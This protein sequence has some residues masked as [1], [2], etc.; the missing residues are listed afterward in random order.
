[1]PSSQ[2]VR[3]Y[4]YMNNA[5]TLAEQIALKILINDPSEKEIQALVADEAQKAGIN[6]NILRHEAYKAYHGASE[7]VSPEAAAEYN[8]R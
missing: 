7:G 3:I 5:A 2:I 4:I 1:M 6:V 8:K